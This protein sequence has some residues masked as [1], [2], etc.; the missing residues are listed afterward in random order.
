[1]GESLLFAYARRS[2]SADMQF[3]LLLKTGSDEGLPSDQ[4]TPRQLPLTTMHTLLGLCQ[5]IHMPLGL[6]DSGALMQCSIEET[7][8]GLDGVCEY[9]DDILIYAPTKEAH[10]DILHKV[11]CRLHVKD[12]HIQLCKCVF[13]M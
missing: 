4:T 2:F 10:N 1:M 6:V 5:Y 3:V 9:I 12:F 13:G 11:L 8:A 7:L